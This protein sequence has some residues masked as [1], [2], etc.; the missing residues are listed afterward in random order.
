MAPTI[1]QAKRILWHPLMKDIGT[2]VGRAFVDSFNI[3][4]LLIEFR[5]GCRLQ[6]F[7]AEGHERVRGSGYDEFICDEADDPRFTDQVFSDTIHPALSDNL[8][9]LIQVGSPKGRGRLYRE[10]CQGQLDSEFYD[11]DTASCQVTA[12]QAGIISLAEI[13]RARRLRP[14]R[15]F[16]QEYEADFLAP[17]GIVYDEWNEKVHLCDERDLPSRFDEIIVGVDWGTAARGAMLVIGFDQSVVRDD[18][19]THRVTRAWVL[20]EHT[21]AGMGY[22]DGGWWALARKIQNKWSPRTW[23]ADP[24][25][26]AEG[27]LRQLENALRSGGRGDVVP[28]NNERAPGIATVREFMHYDEVLK[29]PPRLR[30]MRSCTVFRGELAAYRY[31]AHRTVED[32]FVDEP[33][34]VNDHLC[35]AGRY[36][37]HTHTMKPRNGRSDYGSEDFTQG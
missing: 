36:A 15:A 12:V 20:E 23:Y 37:M 2:K 1:G 33:V 22:D 28:A 25:G 35:D 18:Y 29:E 9:T 19:G 24:A 7:G 32:E 8:G 4:E 13:E 31:R 14:A 30:V 21:H 26:G 3:S 27:Y 34:K 5:N 6:L 17:H 10:F 16:R 11:S